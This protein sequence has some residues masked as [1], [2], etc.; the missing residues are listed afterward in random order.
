M[1]LELPL[2]IFRPF[3]G[4]RILKTGLAVLLSL[5]AFHWVSPGY[6]SFAALFAIL[7]VQPS[8]SRA[9]NT[10][11]HQLIGNLIGGAVAA[12]LGVWLGPT[13]PAMALGVVLVLGMCTRL[14]LTDA[15]SV[16]MTAVLFIMDRPQPDFLLYTAARVGTIT[17]GMLIGYLVNR[18]IRPPDYSTRLRDDLRAAAAGID[19]FVGHLLTSLHAPEHYYKE[20]IKGDAALILKRL[21]TASYF[22]DL[23][24]EAQPPANPNHLPLEKVKASLFVF[25]ERIMDMHKIILQAD[26]LQPGAE[27]GIVAAALRSVLRYKDDVVGAAVDGGT[28]DPA[29]GAACQEALRELRLLVDERVA[30]LETRDRGLALHGLLTNIRHMS[31]RMESLARLLA[32]MVV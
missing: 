31:W 5:I 3:L 27:I 9:R 4:A 8:V 24:H 32:D 10:F 16:A 17:G 21:E 25:V 2:R 29:I 22:L 28:P 19:G 13:A 6:G 26:G 30:D 11:A 15:I 7:A 1:N 12:V 14:G 18:F 23:Y 20:Q